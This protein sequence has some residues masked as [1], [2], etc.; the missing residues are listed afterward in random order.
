LDSQDKTKNHKKEVA[1]HKASTTKKNNTSFLNINSLVSLFIIIALGFISYIGWKKITQQN[2]LLNSQQQQ[3]EQLLSQQSQVTDQVKNQ[4]QQNNLAQQQE[5]STLKETLTAFLKQN[6]HSRRDWLVAEAEYLIKLANHLLV[7]A[8]DVPTSI[9]ALRA[10]DERL[11]DVGNPKFIPLRQALAIDIQKLE[12]L[13]RV[14]IVGLSLTLNAIQKQ[15]E[16]LPLK[17]PDPKTIE[18]KNQHAS[19]LTQAESWQQ[20]PLAIW[21]DLLKLFKVQTHT[22]LPQPL[23]APE[24]RFFLV[25]NLKLQLEQ[26]RLALL[27]NQPIIYKDRVQQAQQ[28]INRYFEA[29]HPLSKSINENLIQ[30]AQ[31]KLNVNLPEIFG[32]LNKLQLINSS[33]KKLLLKNKPSKGIKKRT[34]KKRSVKNK[35]AKKVIS[36][37]KATKP[38]AP[39]KKKSI[40]K[41]TAN[42]QQKLESIKE[43]PIRQPKSEEKTGSTI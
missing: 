24:H 3:L 20:I 25:Q 38:I 33:N 4:L 27:K 2:T 14:D 40:A 43:S 23:L 8:H 39:V 32:S 29:E 13:P 5:F 12:S 9:Y 17:T 7:L 30:L 18:Q 10:A 26:A 37:N 28:W 1:K 42:K 36:K 16:A 15:L 31:I 11:R 41:E 35:P 6:Q 19:E 21:K 34:S 22:E